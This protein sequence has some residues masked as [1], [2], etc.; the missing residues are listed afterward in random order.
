MSDVPRFVCVVW[1]DTY[2]IGCVPFAELTKPESVRR[3]FFEFAREDTENCRWSR[4]AMF[5]TEQRN[6]NRSGDDGE[7]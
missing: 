2:E 6:P 4:G 5:A 7:D 1:K 3:G